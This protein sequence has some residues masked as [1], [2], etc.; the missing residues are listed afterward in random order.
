MEAREDAE[1]NIEDDLNEEE[2]EQPTNRR[3]N[4]EDARKALDES[5]TKQIIGS[6][7]DG[8]VPERIIHVRIWNGN[9]FVRSY[10]KLLNPESLY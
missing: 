8:D 5:L 2:P 1:D 4:P 10:N 3:M 6:F 9:K 7:E